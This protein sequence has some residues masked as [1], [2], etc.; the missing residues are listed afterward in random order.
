MVQ[1]RGLAFLD[2]GQVAELSASETLDHVNGEGTYRG[3]EILTFEDGSTIVS[4]F[5]GEDT[6]SE[7]G[8]LAVFE[9]EFEYIDGSGR[10]EGIDGEGTHTGRNHMASGV[11]FYLD[12]QGTYTLSPD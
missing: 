7:D 1:V 10:F 3:Y 2:D 6:L 9:G 12:F 11:G 5:E 4:R 8:R